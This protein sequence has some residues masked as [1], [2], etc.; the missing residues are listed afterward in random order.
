[1]A[2]IETDPRYK[3]WVLFSF[4]DQCGAPHSR[5]RF[6]EAFRDPPS[7]VSLLRST[8]SDVD[9]VLELAAGL[10]LLLGL[11][12]HSLA[13]VLSGEMAF[14]YF[15]RHVPSGFFPVTVLVISR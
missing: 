13:F 12:S 2:Y 10:P 8:L 7:L 4:A 14:A 5:T 11:F 1:M 15:I 3:V 9:G 6:S